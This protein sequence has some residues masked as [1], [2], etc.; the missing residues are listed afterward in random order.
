M[1]IAAW[2]KPRR[3]VVLVDNESWILP[4][5]ERLV[6]ELQNDGD[7]AQ[8]VRCAENLTKSDVAF[9]LGCVRIVQRSL[10]DKSCFNLVVHE[11]NLPKGR[12]FS[13]M[14]WQIL[15]GETTIP[16]RL[17]KASEDIDAGPIIYLD[18]IELNGNETYEE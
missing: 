16:I 18:N 15:H 17:F 1:T 6:E 3:I 14:T 9:F 4:Y 8:L 11:S 2:K 13:P 5:A 7:T 10:L 12:G